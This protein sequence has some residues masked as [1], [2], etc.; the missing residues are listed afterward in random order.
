[1]IEAQLT[2][3]SGMRFEAETQGH[4]V[5]IDANKEDPAA[6]AGPTPMSLFLVSLAGCSAMDVI[7]ILQKKRLEIAGFQVKISGDRRT[8]PYPLVFEGVEIVYTLRGPNLPAKAVQEAIALSRDRYCAV[9]GMIQGP[10]F[11]HRFVIENPEGN[12]VSEGL[13]E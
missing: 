12:I 3:N 11:R 8:T 5:T 1:M 9:A 7:Y 2:W 13:V 6:G 4:R 10:R